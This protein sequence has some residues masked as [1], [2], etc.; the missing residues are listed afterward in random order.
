MPIYLNIL[1]T[2]HPI[3][4]Y[5]FNNLFFDN[6]YPFLKPSRIKASLSGKKVS[7]FHAF[8]S[9]KPWLMDDNM[10][11]IVYYSTA[12]MPNASAGKVQC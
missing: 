8:V 7:R 6:I 5:F 11:N 2:H 1:W 3:A 12:R 4:F 10:E 9:Q